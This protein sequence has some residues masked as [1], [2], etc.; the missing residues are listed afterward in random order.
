MCVSSKSQ[1]LKF[2]ISASIVDRPL[3]G[4][5]KG[6]GARPARERVLLL[7]FPRLEHPVAPGLCPHLVRPVKLMIPEKL[8]LKVDVH[9]GR[10][11]CSPQTHLR[12]HNEVVRG[13]MGFRAPLAGWRE[14]RLDVVELW[15]KLYRR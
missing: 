4:T 1:V 6:K 9:V 3:F 10:P 2:L 12:R 13:H 7:V 14:R 5:G 15:G 8:R 11:L